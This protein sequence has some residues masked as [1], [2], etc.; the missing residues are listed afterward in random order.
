MAVGQRG[1]PGQDVRAF[2]QVAQLAHV[3]GPGVRAQPGQRRFGQG[4]LPAADARQEMRSQ[5]RDVI[6]ALR[7]ASGSKTAA[8][9]MLGITRRAMYSRMK[10][11]GMDAGPEQ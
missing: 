11:L 7:R 10:M 1:R 5:Q 8:A 9:Q 3:A 2:D 6:E 4:I